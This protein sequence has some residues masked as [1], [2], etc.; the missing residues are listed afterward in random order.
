[1][2]VKAR[3]LI[4]S[5]PKERAKVVNAERRC[6][7]TNSQDVDDNKCTAVCSTTISHAQQLTRHNYYM[8]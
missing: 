2:R 5:S 6:W 7:S 4:Q 3:V 8:H 1:M